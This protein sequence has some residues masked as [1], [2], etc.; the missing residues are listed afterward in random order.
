ME[1]E[2]RHD[3]KISGVGS[4]SGGIFN[5]VI[6]EGKG[7]ISGDLDCADFQT[8]GVSS[9]N[10]SI[11]SITGRINGKSEIKGKLEAKEF[12]ISGSSKI[13][14]NVSVKE[15]KIE[16]SASLSGSLSAEE[17]KIQGG[18]KVK[19][20]CQAEIFSA[21]GAFTIGGLLN[22]GN[23]EVILYGGSQA[24]EIGGEKINI[25]KEK[26]NRIISFFESMLAFGRGLSTDTIEGD[27][28]YLEYTRAKVV[29]GNNVSI[30]PGCVIEL[31]EYRNIFQQV[32]DATVTEHRKLNPE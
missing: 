20:D 1:K 3:L 19:G 13:H 10:G 4:A 31:V 29:R 5:N 28:I 9:I 30:G 17:V 2:T 22:A 7:N 18:V 25:R 27:D 16:G 21:K 24:R 6:I 11:K 12:K 15:I 8:N 32:R 14:D 26:A 23:I